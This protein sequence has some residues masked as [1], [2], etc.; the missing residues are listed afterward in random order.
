M[1]D[2]P[3][4]VTGLSLD[5]LNVSNAFV[6]AHFGFSSPSPV[7]TAYA[8]LQP[9]HR[10]PTRATARLDGFR[11]VTSASGVPNAPSTTLTVASYTPAPWAALLGVLV[12]AAAATAAAAAVVLSTAVSVGWAARGGTAVAPTPS[13]AG[14][15]A[16]SLLGHVQV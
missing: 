15:A 3:Q 13:T 10:L 9:T 6:V 4:P 11:C 14:G 2:F 1:L 16:L 7:S 12:S 5:A 8:L